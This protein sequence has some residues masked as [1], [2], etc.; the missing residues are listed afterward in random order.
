ME[1][2]MVQMKGFEWEKI[3][4][5]KAHQLTDKHLLENI[6]EMSIIGL[7]G[8]GLIAEVCKRLKA[9]SYSND[10]TLTS[11]VG[12]KYTD[13]KSPL[14]IKHDKK[15]KCF[16]IKYTS[17]I[18]DYREIISDEYATMFDSNVGHICEFIK[19]EFRKYSDSDEGKEEE[20][21][22]DE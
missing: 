1:R 13:T 14:T 22:Q 9:Y 16:T 19:E 4:T 3:S 6:K 15:N 10:E 11:I 20:P 7:P 5:Q 17:S 21:E 8:Y 18:R 12:F 2:K